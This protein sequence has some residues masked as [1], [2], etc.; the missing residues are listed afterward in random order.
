MHKDFILR[1]M[2]SDDAVAVAE[3]EKECFSLP[4]SAEALVA[5]LQQNYSYFVVA[6][7]GE[8]IVGYGGVYVVAGEAE[9]I[10]VAVK[11]AYRG[12]GIGKELVMALLAEAVN[13]NAKT[14]FLEVRESNHTAIA[15]YERCGFEKNGIRKNFYEKPVENAVIMWKNEQ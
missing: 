7:V 9:I 2:T 10:N 13:R 3:I 8:D 1:E 6:C 5:S 15:L 12:N 11:S 4:W 14:A